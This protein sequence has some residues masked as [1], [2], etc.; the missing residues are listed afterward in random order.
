MDRRNFTKG[1]IGM[2]AMICTGSPAITCIRY[3]ANL[4]EKEEE[5]PVIK[6]VGVGTAGCRVVQGLL[7]KRFDSSNCLLISREIS[8]LEQIECQ[9]RI[10]LREIEQL[11]AFESY[12]DEGF[13]SFIVQIFQTYEAAIITK[14]KGADLI[15]IVAGMGW[16]TGTIVAPLTAK[17]CRGFKAPIVAFATTP[18]AWEGGAPSENAAVGLVELRKYTDVFEACSLEQ[19]YP[20]RQK[21]R[22]VGESFE[23]GIDLMQQ[24]VLYLADKFQ[25]RDLKSWIDNQGANIRFCI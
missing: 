2:G 21:T 1:L 5:S 10:F 7:S 11:S 4:V 9:N 3:L 25:R 15:F 22:T 6:L 20:Y 16:L 14:L 12:R 8:D 17:I 19:L 23:L 24:K 13:S 18:F